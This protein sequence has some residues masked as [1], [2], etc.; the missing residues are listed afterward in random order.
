[1]N[2]PPTSCA[3]AIARLLPVSLG[4]P[5]GDPTPIVAGTQSAGPAAGA[6]S[7]RRRNLGGVKETCPRCS[8]EMEWRHGTF[9][10]PK[11]R[12]KIGCCEG[13]T[14]DCRDPG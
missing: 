7:A 1:M 13:E 3:S 10:C 12:L 6:P 2:R 14:G 4:N 5:R 9:Q 11:C 8:A